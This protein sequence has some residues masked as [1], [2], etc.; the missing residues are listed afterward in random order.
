[1]QEEFLV[2]GPM[3]GASGLKHVWPLLYHHLLGQGVNWIA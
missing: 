1:M 2:S 3:S